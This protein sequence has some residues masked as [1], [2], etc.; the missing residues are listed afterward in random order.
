MLSVHFRA[1]SFD[2]ISNLRDVRGR[3]PVSYVTPNDRPRQGERWGFR[4]RVLAMILAAGR[5]G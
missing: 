1:V 2:G 3:L 4:E 5:E